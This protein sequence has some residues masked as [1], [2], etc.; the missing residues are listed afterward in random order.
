MSSRPVQT[1]LKLTASVGPLI[2]LIGRQELVAGGSLAPI[3][4]LSCPTVQTISS[5]PFDVLAA[6]L[7]FT[8]ALIR[9]VACHGR[10]SGCSDRRCRGRWHCRPRLFISSRSRPRRGRDA[11]SWFSRGVP[12]SELFA[13][14]FTGRRRWRCFPTRSCGCRSTRTPDSSVTPGAPVSVVDVQASS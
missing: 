6:V 11:Q 5:A 14:G 8:G 2:V 13:T 7:R 3:P 12:G 1:L 9:L 4:P 10:S